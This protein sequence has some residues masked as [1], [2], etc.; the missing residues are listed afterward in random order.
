[1]NISQ[2]CNMHTLLISIL[3]LLLGLE[4]RYD[5]LVQLL[6]LAE[7]LDGGTDRTCL[8]MNIA[9]KICRVLVAHVV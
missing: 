4:G 3:A 8:C 2:T 1:M 6:L 5:E 9:A 7:E